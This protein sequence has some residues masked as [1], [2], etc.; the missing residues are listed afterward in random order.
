MIDPTVA[1]DKIASLLDGAANADFL[2]YER[3][4]GIR[5][6]ANR[7]ALAIWFTH[8]TGY[9]TQ[10]G[11]DTFC[12]QDVSGGD[13]ALFVDGGDE[14][15]QAFPFTSAISEFIHQFDEG[16]YADLAAPASFA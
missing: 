10:V 14:D 15:W 4:K 13:I 8:V 7:C 11:T 2:R 12:D 1:Y 16:A 5:G 3:I 9:E 6:N